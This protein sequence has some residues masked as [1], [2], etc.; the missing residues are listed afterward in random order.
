MSVKIIARN[1]QS[2]LKLNDLQAKFKDGIRLAYIDISKYLKA[3][4]KEELNDEK[5]GRVYIRRIGGRL[6]RHRAS[7]PD[8]S[9]ATFTGKLE[10]SIATK[11]SG[12][13]QLDFSAGGGKVN[14]AGFLEKGTRKMAKR[15][16]MIKSINKNER[17]AIEAFYRNISRRINEA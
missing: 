8:E 17:N 3:T 7:A 6:V 15:P 16:Y 14:Y 12:F 11:T 2:L 1:Q 4:V 10:N 13:T 5:H 9:P